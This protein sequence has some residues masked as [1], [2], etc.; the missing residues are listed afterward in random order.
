M[1]H[2]KQLIIQADSSV[3]TYC[4]YNVSSD[5]IEKT[6]NFV[7]FSGIDVGLYIWFSIHSGKYDC[8]KILLEAGAW[9]D[10]ADRWIQTP[11]MYSVCTERPE[12]VDLLLQAGCDPDKKDRLVIS[13][14]LHKWSLLFVAISHCPALSSVAPVKCAVYR[15]HCMWIAGLSFGPFCAVLTQYAFITIEGNL[16]KIIHL[17]KLISYNNLM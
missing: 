10:P 5:G 1:G 16:R 6:C 3:R 15:S 14:P 4:S 13:D 12:M 9:L 11:L 8:A 2:R 7:S 17:M